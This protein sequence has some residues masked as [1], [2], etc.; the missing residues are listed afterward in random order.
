MPIADLLQQA[1]Y[2]KSMTSLIAVSEGNY[3]VI[4]GRRRCYVSRTLVGAVFLHLE[5][6]AFCRSL[7]VSSKL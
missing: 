4:A 7:P 6:D 2:M 1:N 3:I 5:P